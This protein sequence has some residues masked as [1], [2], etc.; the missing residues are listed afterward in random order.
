MEPKEPLLDPPL[1]RGT[2]IPLFENIV[3]VSKV[4]SYEEA[5]PPM[6]SH[7]FYKSLK[8]LN[9]FMTADNVIR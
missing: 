5:R 8:C 7:Y 6:S 2:T 9:R 4:F 3:S 1:G